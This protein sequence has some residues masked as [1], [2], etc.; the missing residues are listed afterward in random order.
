MVYTVLCAAVLLLAMASFMIGAM[1]C[2]DDE[3]GKKKKASVA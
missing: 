2:F 1:V 3:H